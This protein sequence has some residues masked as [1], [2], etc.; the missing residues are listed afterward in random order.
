M[1]KKKP[2]FNRQEKAI[3]KVLFEHRRPMSIRELAEKTNM[4]WVTAKKYIKKL[5]ERGWILED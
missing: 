2:S 5:K 3:L 4:S 1:P